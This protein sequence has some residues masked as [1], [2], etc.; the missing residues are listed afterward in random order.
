MDY[1]KL[2]KIVTSSG[3]LV[4]AGK[5][6]EQN[7]EIVK[8]VLPNETVLHT[9]AAGSPFCIIKGKAT[10]R[11]IYETA[12]FCAKYSR[13]WKKG[14]KNKDIEIHCFKGKDI[15]KSK[16]MKIGTFGVKKLRLIKVKK[17][18]IEDIKE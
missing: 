13:T 1:S 3:K 15:F 6:A 10:E 4:I 14:N 12:A 11:D 9:E 5:N 8:H 16:N 17:E 2:R 18:D 7:E